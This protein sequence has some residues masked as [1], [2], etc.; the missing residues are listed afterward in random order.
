MNFIKL[1]ILTAVAVFSTLAIAKG[2][3]YGT[4]NCGSLKPPKGA[5]EVAGAEKYKVI[6]TPKGYFILS[7]PGRAPAPKPVVR[8]LT[9]KTPGME[10]EVY[11][12]DDLDVIVRPKTMALGKRGGVIVTIQRAG[13]PE[14]NSACPFEKKGF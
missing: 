11:S 10:Q 8:R 3:P 5:G 2:D 9:L 4:Y 1:S 6:I 12:I 7:T 14:W 13:N